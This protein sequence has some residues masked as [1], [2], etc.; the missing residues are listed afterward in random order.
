[1]YPRALSMYHCDDLREV[2]RI[3]M[4]ARAR[5]LLHIYAHMRHVRV[6]GILL[7]H[8]RVYDVLCCIVRLVASSRVCKVRFPIFLR[9][10]NV[11]TRRKQKARV[12]GTANV[13]FQKL[14]FLFELALTL[15]LSLSFSRCACMRARARVH[16]CEYS[17]CMHIIYLL[18]YL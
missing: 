9:S 11:T 17:G 12:R 4:H 5:A 18:I 15:S 1:M 10:R 7:K 14:D 13:A 2:L 3:H 6:C 8:A 16:A